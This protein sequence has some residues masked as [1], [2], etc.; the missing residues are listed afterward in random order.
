MHQNW[1]R[2]I[3]SIK[4][5][6]LV[7]GSQRV[8][9]K[10]QDLACHSERLFATQLLWQWSMNL[11]KV[12]WCR[13]QECLSTFTMLLVEASSE[14]KLFWHLSNNVFGVRNFGKTKVMRVI[15]LFETL[16]IS[17]RF[18]KCSKKLRKSFLFV[19]YLHLNWYC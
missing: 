6:I 7:M 3:V 11:I 10:S 2:Q 9:K 16:K 18:Q 14:T 19:R 17:T 12:L 15:F 4:N 1:H 8:K 13:F 5:R